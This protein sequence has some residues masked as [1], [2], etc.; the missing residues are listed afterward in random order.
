MGWREFADGMAAIRPEI[1]AEMAR[2][3]PEREAA[4]SDFNNRKWTLAMCSVLS[5][6]EKFSGNEVRAA[7][8]M[9]ARMI[10]DG[11]WTARI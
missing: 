11:T 8:S 6:P 1:Q 7:E 2:R 4:R 5:E 3:G 10:E 9:K